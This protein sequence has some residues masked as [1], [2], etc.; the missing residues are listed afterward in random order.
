MHAK[1]PVCFL[2]PRDNEQVTVLDRRVRSGVR[3]VPAPAGLPLRLDTAEL[4]APHLR[5]AGSAELVM[6][7]L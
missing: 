4:L 1:S 2:L 7:D 5:T 3:E 6:A